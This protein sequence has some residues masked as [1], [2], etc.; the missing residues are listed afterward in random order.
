MVG[1]NIIINQL[2]VG[3]ISG[4]EGLTST[5]RYHSGT[6]VS[7]PQFNTWKESNF[8]I[9][10]KRNLRIYS[11]FSSFRLGLGMKGGGSLIGWVDFGIR[12]TVRLGKVL[13]VCK[14]LKN[15][16]KTF[17][18]HW[19]LPHR[20][21]YRSKMIFSQY[22]YGLWVSKDAEFYVDSKNINLY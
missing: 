10:F 12:T 7:C 9:S 16:L 3:G 4:N 20:R 15:M 13:F 22:R 21:T 19:P 5:P 6:D 2:K 11:Y 8:L 17:L 14:S 1:L 18:V